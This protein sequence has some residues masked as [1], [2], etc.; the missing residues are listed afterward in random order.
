ML[1]IAQVIRPTASVDD[2]ATI[3]ARKVKVD[4]LQPVPLARSSHLS[5]WSGQIS[6]FPIGPNIAI[7]Q[8]LAMHVEDYEKRHEPGKGSW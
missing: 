7:G 8:S 6:G 5:L 1:N 2:I 4:I 3:K